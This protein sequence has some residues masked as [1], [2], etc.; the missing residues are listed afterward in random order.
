[1]DLLERMRLMEFRLLEIHANRVDFD[2]HDKSLIRGVA[3]WFE[4]NEMPAPSLHLPFEENWQTGEKRPLSVL[5]PEL[6]RREYVMDEIKRCLV[7]GERLALAHVVLHLGVA[8]QEF[9]PVMFDYAYA[10]VAT[11]ERFAG[12][13]VLIE[14]LANDISTVARLRE[15]KTVSGLQS[16]GICYDTGHAHLEKDKVLPDVL[17]DIQAI[18]IDDNDGRADNHAW[19]FEG[20]TN[21]PRFAEQLVVSGFAFPLILEPD[22]ERL[23]RAKDCRSRLI[24]LLQEAAVS[25]EEFR[26][27]HKLSRNNNQ[28]ED[29]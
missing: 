25:L 13:R 24:E 6:R 9:N 5:D 20:T 7:L 8:G 18:H 2:F 29:S 14:N 1:V 12:V 4:E 27:K 15:F 21:W 19:P 3:R 11:I 23:E 22:D 17:D 28:Y 16:V 10:A 26:L